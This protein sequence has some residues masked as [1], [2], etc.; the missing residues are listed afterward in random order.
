MG[1]LDESERSRIPILFFD[2]RTG[3]LSGQPQQSNALASGVEDLGL[4]FSL[5]FDK[6]ACTFS[7]CPKNINTTN[8]QHPH[9][10]PTQFSSF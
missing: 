10:P 7:S 6:T 2:D 9:Q 1:D 8:S 5:L 4:N 3:R